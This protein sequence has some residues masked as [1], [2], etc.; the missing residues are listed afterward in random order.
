MLTMFHAATSLLFASTFLF[1]PTSSAPTSMVISRQTG[2][3]QCADVMVFFARG[4]TEPAPIGTVVGPPLKAALKSALG[5]KSMSFMGVDYPADIPGFLQGGSP[6]GSRTMAKD[7]TNAA[8]ACPK[9][10]LVTVGYS[11]GAQLVHNSAQQLSPDVQSRVA[12]ALAFGDPLNG[13][14]VTGVSADQTKVICHFGDNICAGGN[15]V[16]APHLTYGRD[17]RDAA[18]FVASKV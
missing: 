7:L 18:K 11:Q 17:T 8:N 4:T 9:A 6:E 3:A 2:G 5:Q 13:Q 14:P 16:L 12:A 15:L 1:S 10:A